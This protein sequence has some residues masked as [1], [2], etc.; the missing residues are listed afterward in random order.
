MD[1]N[2]RTYPFVGNVPFWLLDLACIN[3]HA[4]VQPMG[5]DSSWAP[6]FCTYPP[7]ETT[8]LGV[9]ETLPSPLQPEISFPST[10]HY[11]NEL[12]PGG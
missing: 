7:A 11:E 9:L 2:F 1:P 4:T 12:G 5:F 6:N 3:F 8:L 10:L